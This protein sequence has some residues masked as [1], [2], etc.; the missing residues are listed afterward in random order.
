MEAAE[1]YALAVDLGTHQDL[2]MTMNEKLNALIDREVGVDD[3]SFMP[4][5]DQL[6]WSV[7]GRFNV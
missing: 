7:Q 1:H 3:G 6:P 5:A 4:K 2:I